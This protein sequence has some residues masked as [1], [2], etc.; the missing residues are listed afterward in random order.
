MS[1]FTSIITSNCYYTTTT[2]LAW[3]LVSKNDI[4][5]IN[6]YLTNNVEENKKLYHHII[7]TI[8]EEEIPCRCINDHFSKEY[9]FYATEFDNENENENEYLIEYKYEVRL[10]TI[11]FSA[12]SQN[13]LFIL[14]HFWNNTIDINHNPGKDGNCHSLITL[15]VG[16]YM[17]KY[18]KNNN[19]EKNNLN[20]ENYDTIIF[21]MNRYLKNEDGRSIWD[22]RTLLF[23]ILNFSGY[24][25]NY[26]LISTLLNKHNELISM[27]LN[28]YNEYYSLNTCYDIC[29]SDN[30]TKTFDWSLD[31]CYDICISRNLKKTFDWIIK[32]Y[33]NDIDFEWTIKILDEKEIYTNEDI[34]MQNYVIEEMKLL[35]STVYEK[36]MH[37]L[38][39]EFFIVTGDLSCNILLGNDILH[40]PEY[41]RHIRTTE[42]F[43]RK[44]NNIEFPNNLGFSIHIKFPKNVKSIQ[45][46]Y[47]FDQSLDNI[48]FPDSLEIIKFG[49]KFNKSLD[50]V[51]FP[52][53]VKEISFG[54][55]NN[56][57]DF[58]QSIKNIVFPA[59]LK[60]FIN[61]GECSDEIE[62][63][64]FPKTIEI[65]KL[66]RNEDDC[67]PDDIE[68][69]TIES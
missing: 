22:H 8:P 29:I 3:I 47:E 2:R 17:D 28:K 40:I 56:W 5:N 30:L 9:F 10:Y 24:Y 12:I 57:S 63:I 35:N 32:N 16:N 23:D 45:F 64:Q 34:E 21:I 7:S 51:K 59:S 11:L 33:I 43:N 18:E 6:N 66:G 36:I 15:A 37:L 49:S 38:N 60:K 19:N 20:K 1:R 65:I 25:N 68:C 42:D 55:D 39:T 62:D 69:E 27:L 4:Q 52:D 41:I 58:N 67:N 53:S 26:E 14:N 48:N 13:N 44:I 31:T 61:F 46:G 54:E 50:N